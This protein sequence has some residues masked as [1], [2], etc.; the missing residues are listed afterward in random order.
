MKNQRGAVDF[1]EALIATAVIVLLVMMVVS[2][3][4]DKYQ[5]HEC[6]KANQ[7]RPAIEVKLLC[8]PR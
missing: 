6:M 3:W 4:W 2:F 8:G 5:T 1:L 7:S